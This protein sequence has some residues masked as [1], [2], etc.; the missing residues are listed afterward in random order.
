MVVAAAFQGL[1]AIGESGDA[2]LEGSGTLTLLI[3]RVRAILWAAHGL[4]KA[5][6]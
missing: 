3:L 6:P 4:F 1:P 2:S 5:L